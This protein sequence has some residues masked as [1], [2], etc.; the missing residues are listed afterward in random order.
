M[1]ARIAR[2]ASDRID[3]VNEYLADLSDGNYQGAYAS[4]CSSA[5]DAVTYDQFVATQQGVEISAY[6]ITGFEQT[7]GL[8]TVSGTVSYNGSEQLVD[9]PVV[10]EG[11]EWRP[12]PVL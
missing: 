1:T 4:L 8:T 10:Q 12:C 6:N 7:N 2:A 11:E 9:I 3:P 5:Q